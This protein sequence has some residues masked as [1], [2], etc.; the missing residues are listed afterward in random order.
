M[1]NK[2]K[3]MRTTIIIAVIVGAALIFWGSGE[4]S[5]ADEMGKAGDAKVMAAV[6]KEM[7]KSLPV[8]VDRDTELYSVAGFEKMITYNY[9]FINVSANE[10]PSEKVLTTFKPQFISSACASPEIRNTFFKSGITMRYTFSDKDK[11]PITSFDITLAD[12]E[13]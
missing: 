6:A 11:K 9:R 13:V 1:D 7:N 3:K 10:F 8:M 12:C 5:W 4:S 2:N